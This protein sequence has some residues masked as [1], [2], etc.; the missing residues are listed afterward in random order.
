MKERDNI[1]EDEHDSEASHGTADSTESE[2]DAAGERD[3]GEGVLG[4]SRQGADDSAE[5]DAVERDGE[6]D[7]SAADSSHQELG[8][9]GP[10]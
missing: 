8:E 9:E 1:C 6:A 5:E 3:K 7:Q 10:R 4:G 2:P